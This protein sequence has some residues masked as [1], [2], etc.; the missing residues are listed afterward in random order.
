M[1]KHFLC[2][3]TSLH[4][5][6]AQ[7]QSVDF[8]Q[9]YSVL[10]REVL[11]PTNLSSS[12]IYGL[13]MFITLLLLSLLVSIIVS[14]IVAWF[15]RIPIQK[16]LQKFIPEDIVNAW[17]RFIIFALYVVGISGGNRIWEYEKYIGSTDQTAVAALTSERWV[18]E[19][20][21]TMLDTLQSAAWMLFFFFL[22]SVAA[23]LLVRLIEIFKQS[24][25]RNQKPE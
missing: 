10:I 18:L 19:L 4:R 17:Y 3:R 8:P 24:R 13:I 16:I 11:P 2:D 20:Y 22:F 21:R 6:R 14:T 12:L 7:K 5:W 23:I 9:K 15:F 25:V 1:G